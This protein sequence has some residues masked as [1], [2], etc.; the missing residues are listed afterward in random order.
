MKSTL[1][2][3]TI[4]LASL[5]VSNAAISISGTALS[6]IGAANAP[7][8]SLI[9]FVVDTGGDGF[10]GN[11]ALSGDLT[12][13]N[14]PGLTAAQAGININTTFGGDLVV[15]RAAVSSAGS[16]VGTLTD[17]DN[18]AGTFQNKNFALIWLP[19]LTTSSTTL[20]AGQIF[21]ITSGS[22][23]TLPAANAGQTYSY[24]T[25]SVDETT[26]FRPTTTDAT[27]VTLN[28]RF[29]TSGGATFSIIPEPSVAL[30][31][32]LGVFGL[33]RRRR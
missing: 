10:F 30:L 32:A 23:W 5:S 13:A 4:G 28:D 22:D 14:N 6:G 1:L 18:L 31:G 9:L 7:A 20:A 17:F 26:F 12:A 25:A 3:A 19:G 24:S 29:T 27:D 2:A 16:L 8:G 33:I 11:A 21:G 15:G